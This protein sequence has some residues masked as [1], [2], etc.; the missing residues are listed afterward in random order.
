MKNDHNQKLPTA[1]YD[2]LSAASSHDC[3]GLIP[4]GPVTD[5]AV[6]HYEEL[7]PFLPKAVM[8]KDSGRQT[9]RSTNTHKY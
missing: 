8:P 4:T 6:E 1:E 5:E 3:T 2:Y 7:Y 9:D